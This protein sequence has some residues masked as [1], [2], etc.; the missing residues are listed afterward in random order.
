MSK[1]NSS[2]NKTELSRM[3]DYLGYGGS[4]GGSKGPSPTLGSPA[5][6]TSAGCWEE[7]SP[8]FGCENH[9]TL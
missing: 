4:C 6:S 5:W 1:I 3:E 7:K 9:W 8:T 2:L